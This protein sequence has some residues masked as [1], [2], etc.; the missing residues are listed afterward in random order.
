[1][2]RKR[3]ATRDSV[4]AETLLGRSRNNSSNENLD[5]SDNAQIA[6][7]EFVPAYI[8]QLLPSFSAKEGEDIE[9]FFVKIENVF[10]LAPNL[11]A[12]IKGVLL[13]SKLQDKAAD[14]VLHDPQIRQV[15][16]YQKIRKALIQRYHKI[17]PKLSGQQE[18]AKITQ[19]PKMSVQDLAQEIRVKAVK[20]LGVTERGPVMQNMLDKMMCMKFLDAIRQDI[21][22]ELLK[23][24]IEDFEEALKEAIILE[25][26]FDNYVT[27]QDE[28]DKV[29][30]M[31]ELM[32]HL[33][34]R[35]I[36]EEIKELKENATPKNEAEQEIRCQICKRINHT[37]EICFYR[38]QNINRGRYNYARGQNI[39]GRQ[40]N[41][42]IFRGNNVSRPWRGRGTYHSQQNRNNPLNY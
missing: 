24:K 13:K 26:I 33:E 29:T 40:Q 20:V 8:T 15:N 41:R 27:E 17:K 19:T 38:N 37:A 12:D 35:K 5:I 42:G 36:S 7:T 39:R 25:N 21:K 9:D 1:M 18:F 34:I 16:N 3:N 14:F 11:G 28:G 23:K 10:S 6:N 22:V 30:A 2:G 31:Q 4:S 32:G